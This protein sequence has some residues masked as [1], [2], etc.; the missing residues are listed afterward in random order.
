[1]APGDVTPMTTDA[2]GPASVP[3]TGP[4]RIDGPPLGYQPGLDG[5]RAVAVGIVLLYHFTL[6]FTGGL[7]G[8]D[9]FFVLSGFLITTLL[10]DERNRS[11]AIS[12]R[13]FYHR[14]VLR[15]F[16]AMYALL[17][18]VA[19]V[20][21]PFRDELPLYWQEITSAALYSYWLVPV[22]GGLADAGSPRALFPLWSLSVEEW[23][24]FFWP[25]ALMIGLATFRRQRWLIG[26]AA[27]CA[28]MWMGIRLYSGFIG[29]DWKTTT[30]FA[31]TNVDYAGEVIFRMSLLRF[32]MLLA[33]C[34][35]A[36]FLRRLQVR[37]DGPR[38]RWLAPAAVVGTTI[39]LAQILLSDR[40]AF[41]A[42]WS[43]VGFNLALLGIVPMVAWIYL[44]PSSRPVKFLSLPLL[45]WIGRR[46]YGIYL[47]HE[48][49]N[50][51]VP[52]PVGKPA[53]LLRAAI[54][55]VIT[56]GVAELSWRFIESPFLRRKEKR[57]GESGTR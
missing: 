3:A 30:P 46:S 45:V 32:D 4:I 38:P 13:G 40:V 56:L 37:P 12:L 55:G 11:G 2:A 22:F 36:I 43:S 57:Y 5:A 14:R 18:L 28:A 16:P 31:G 49:V 17:A 26:L 39:L 8:V 6:F 52:A 47:W 42:P 23:F 15:L 21:F 7:I 1:M 10:L 35:L 50:V 24:Y 48:V 9:I 54:L 19:V 25:A 44:V 27:G 20:A 51:L 53:I 29:V 33:G 34:L 41:F